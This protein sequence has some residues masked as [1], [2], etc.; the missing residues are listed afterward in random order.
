MKAAKDG[1]RKSRN[2]AKMSNR[3]TKTI[4]VGNLETKIVTKKASGADVQKQ[5][6]EN[7]KKYRENKAEIKQ[8]AKKERRHLTKKE[9][10]E[11]AI[12]KVMRQA[13]KEGKDVKQAVRD[14]KDKHR[15]SVH[16]RGAAR[17]EH[18][19]HIRTTIRALIKKARD[20][21]KQLIKSAKSD[22]LKKAARAKVAQRVQ[23]LRGQRALMLNKIG[24]K[25]AVPEGAKLTGAAAKW[26]SDQMKARGTGRN[27]AGIKLNPQ[28][29]SNKSM[30]PTKTLAYREESAKRSAEQK[31]RFQNKSK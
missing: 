7:Q 2:A 19:K 20:E 18:A 28:A 23:K 3:K 26:H 31:A 14:F 29:A 8:E 27:K 15:A 9:K 13:A 24:I 12:K 1:N 22:D 16:E 5:R 10:M 6:R 25:V 4:K 30:K 21:G 11:I 17:Q